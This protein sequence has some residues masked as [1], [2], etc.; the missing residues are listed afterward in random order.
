MATAIKMMGRVH[1]ISNDTL[2]TLKK[3]F[4]GEVTDVIRS[5]KNIIRLCV[6]LFASVVAVSTLSPAAVAA[7][8][9][10]Q[11]GY[12]GTEWHGDY[13]GEEYT[14]ADNRVVL[15]VYENNVGRI[16]FDAHTVTFKWGLIWHNASSSDPAYITV[17]GRISQGSWYQ[18]FERIGVRQTSRNDWWFASGRF[19]LPGCGTYDV[20]YTYYQKGPYWDQS[21][22]DINATHDDDRIEVPCG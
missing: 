12:Y 4:D 16:Y 19:N 6:A 11:P 3:Y 13:G 1:L 15:S 8:A 22:D 10:A 2:L 18:D 5:F 20:D 14:Y 9:D 21:K 17:R 7:V